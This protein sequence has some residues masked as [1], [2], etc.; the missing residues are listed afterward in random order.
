MSKNDV[1]GMQNV[2]PSGHFWWH[3]DS[4]ESSS[5][6]KLFWIVLVSLAFIACK[7]DIN[8]TKNVV[9]LPNNVVLIIQKCPPDINIRTI[10]NYT[11]SNSCDLSYRNDNLTDHNVILPKN[12]KSDTI[13]IE[14]YRDDVEVMHL[15]GFEGCSYLFNRGDTILFTY[16]GRIPHAD[17]ISRK[18]AN[19]DVNY[20]VFMR[21][22][23]QNNDC[24][25]IYKAFNPDFFHDIGYNID[26]INK[27]RNYYMSQSAYEFERKIQLTDSLFQHDLLSPAMYSYRKHNLAINILSVT[28]IPDWNDS[29]YKNSRIIKNALTDTIEIASMNDSALYFNYYKIY[30][31]RKLSSYLQKIKPIEFSD[32]VSLN[33]PAKF[34][35]ISKLGFFSPKAKQLFLRDCIDEMKRVND[36]SSR[37]MQQSQLDQYIHKYIEITG[38]STVI[39]TFTSKPSVDFSETKHLVLTDSTGKKTN[40][41]EVLNKYKDKVVYVDFWA[42]WCAPCLQGMPSSNK[43]RVEYKN[44]DVVF[45]FLALNDRREKW[46]S[47]IKRLKIDYQADN[48][49][50]ENAKDSQLLI[51][52]EV[53]TIPR[54]LL[55]DKKGALVNQ[56]APGAGSSEIRNLLNQ[57]LK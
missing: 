48:Y 34:D 33:I 46:A 19:Y 44:K 29:I 15:F 27:Y 1:L 14:T 55:F 23:A 28:N 38:D 37:R 13:I 10:G 4:C 9:E 6:M 24:S 57:L 3:C 5:Y 21:E 42:S 20:D 35:T 56:N 25:A 54:Y 12:R 18:T 36:D 30:L 2:F 50:I 31:S 39:M 8:N 22:K 11:V 51:D 45:I 53:N 16:N 40:F 43:L 7:P 41:E 26:S 32:G 17:I 47:E 49:F 52:L